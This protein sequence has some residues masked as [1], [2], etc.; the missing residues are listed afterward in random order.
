M[1]Q[2]IGWKRADQIHPLRA[3]A[4]ERRNDGFDF[5]PAEM[6][7]FAGMT[8]QHCHGDTRL[9]NGKTIDQVDVDDVKF[10]LTTCT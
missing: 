10:L 3:Q 5:F 8:I 6:S 2:G 1:E 9:G 7:R 4:L